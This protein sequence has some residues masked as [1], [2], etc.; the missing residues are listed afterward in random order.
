M[1]SRLLAAPLLAALLIGAFAAAA[2]AVAGRL[3]LSLR[4]ERPASAR[5]A[6]VSGSLSHSNSRD[7]QAILSASGMR[8]G[9]Q[10]SGDVTIANDGDIAGAFRL[11]RPG[12]DEQ[13][14]IG[15]GTLSTRLLLQVLDVTSATAPLTVWAG[16]L[17]AFTTVD[18]GTFT[19][20]QARTYRLVATFPEGGPADNAWAGA[21]STVRF[22]WTSMADDTGVPATPQGPSGTPPSS[23]PVT[24]GSTTRTTSVAIPGA[25]VRL[26]LPSGCVR[27]GASF[28]ATL[29]WKRVKRKGSVFVKVRR[30]DFIVNGKRVMVDR[31]APFVANFKI[32]LSSVA[33][34]T[35]TVR[36]RAYIK[37]RRGKSPT[38]SIRATVR[39][40]E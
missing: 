2:L 10:V 28:R 39:V 33:G 27:R 11:S 1:T 40:C 35:L 14:G 15:G 38:K 23:T 31:R 19:P 4:S 26:T 13:P 17:G 12:I 16:G 6:A 34:A 24:P 18:L 29:G 8:P 7:G 5:A 3:P 36:A 30:T 32:P 37:V 21:T 20:G 22:D 9:S 25:I